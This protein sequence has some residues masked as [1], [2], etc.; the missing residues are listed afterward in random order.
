MSFDPRLD[1]TT[2][3]LTGTVRLVGG[4]WQDAPTAATDHA[5]P[6]MVP[7]TPTMA[8]SSLTARLQ[9]NGRASTAGDAGRYELRARLGSGATG[10]VWAL[11]DRSLQRPL[12]AKVL[13]RGSGDAL[14]AFIEEARITAALEHP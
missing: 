3:P 13:D 8:G 7:A 5:S 1:Q 6:A 14:D 4:A 12:A 11:F 10:S 9:K 2:R